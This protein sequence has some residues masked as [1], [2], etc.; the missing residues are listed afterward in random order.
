MS[1]WISLRN[2]FYYFGINHKNRRRVVDGQVRCTDRRTVLFDIA[3]AMNSL[4]EHYSSSELLPLG[5]L[6][7]EGIVTFFE[8]DYPNNYPPK[9]QLVKKITWLRSKCPELATLCDQL[10]TLNQ[11]GD[12]VT[13]EAS[14]INTAGDYV[15]MV[16]GLYSALVTLRRSVDSRSRWSEEVSIALMRSTSQTNRP[17]CELWDVDEDQM[18]I[19]ET[20]LWLQDHNMEAYSLLFQSLGVED[21]EVL[22]VIREQMSIPDIAKRD[23]DVQMIISAIEHS[24]AKPGHRLSI[25]KLILDLSLDEVKSYGPR[26]DEAIT[27]SEHVAVAMAANLQ[28]QRAERARMDQERAAEQDRKVQITRRL[29]ELRG[30]KFTVEQYLQQGYQLADL[31]DGFPL[32]HLRSIGVQ[33]LTLLSLG[34][35]RQALLRHGYVEKDLHTYDELLALSMTPKQLLDLGY[36]VSELKAR[37]M[38][39]AQ[40]VPHMT[41]GNLLQDFTYQEMV[42]AGIFVLLR[43]HDDWVRSVIELRD[44]SLCSGSADNSI[45][46]WDRASGRCMSSLQGHISDVWSVIELQDGFLCSGSGD[47][48]I[49]IWK[50]TSGLCVSTLRGHRNYVASVIE[51]RDGLLCS[52]SYDKTIKIW[53]RNSGQCVNTLQ[54]HSNYVSSVI[55]LRDGFLCSGSEDKTIKIW[56]RKSGQCVS[57]LQGH[58]NFVS[59]V[60]ELSDGS[61]CSGSYDKTIKVWDRTSLQCLLTLQGHDHWIY[62]VVELQDGSLCSGSEDTTIKIWDR[63]SGQCVSTLQGH[64]D[65]VR[66]VIQ[67]C[68]GSICSSSGDKSIKIWDRASGRCVSSLQGHY[69]WLWSVFGAGDGSLCSES[70]SQTIK[71]WNK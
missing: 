58:D 29:Q 38:T 54:G 11:L 13:I 10:D 43:G 12:Q 16:D 8:P 46:I 28:A 26:K 17:D 35:D 68:D 5:R 51:L 44:G 20:A 14:P 19:T 71:I 53:D 41:V 33:G 22:W 66:S 6:I 37:G 3:K 27:E 67:L 52:G 2:F 36:T 50:R 42:N 30:L 25:K 48:T 64:D 15:A 40:L 55:E 21:L 4:Q 59:S 31:V 7:V 57:T 49:K 56:D 39:A 9:Y 63:I 45:K 34:I 18:K 62:T 60:I 32:D 65:G 70:E 1:E 24:V 69:H 61:M 47:Y 23:P